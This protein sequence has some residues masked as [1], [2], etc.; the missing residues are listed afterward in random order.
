MMTE[1]F[2]NFFQSNFRTSLSLHLLIEFLRKTWN[3][4]EQVRSFFEEVKKDLHVTKESDWYRISLN[5]FR[6]V[7][8]IPLSFSPLP[9]PR[10]S[11]VEYFF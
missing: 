3:T 8:G 2:P 10:F 9:P 4:P 1:N 6:S 5:Q 7:G 11:C